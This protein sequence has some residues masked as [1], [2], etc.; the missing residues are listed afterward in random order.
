[1][2]CFLFL[3]LFCFA[4]LFTAS[5]SAYGSSQGLGTSVCHNVARKIKKKKK[6]LI[7]QSLD[8]SSRLLP[9]CGTTDCINTVFPPQMHQL[10]FPV[11]FLILEYS[12]SGTWSVIWVKNRSRFLSCCPLLTHMCPDLPA[13]LTALSLMI[14]FLAIQVLISYNNSFLFP[15][16]TALP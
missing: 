8:V 6:T 1:M 14:F 4:S 7:C 5:P 9:A 15:Y 10:W 12:Y 13:A 11:C 3:F 16:F 2:S